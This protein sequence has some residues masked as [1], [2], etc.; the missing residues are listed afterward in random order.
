MRILFQRFRVYNVPVNQI[1][2]VCEDLEGFKYWANVIRFRTQG[3]PLCFLRLF[4]QINY[5]V[6]CHILHKISQFLSDIKRA[7]LLSGY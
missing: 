1:D 7:N 3:S 2:E 6:L 4:T 5:S